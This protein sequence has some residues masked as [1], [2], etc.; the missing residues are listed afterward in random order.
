MSDK[1][2]S[3][4]TSSKPWMRFLY[5]VLFSLALYVAIFVTWF[6][7][8]A[9]FLFSLFT[10]SDNLPLRRFC[11]SFS[12]FIYQVIRYLT[13]N[14]E[15]KP[16]PFSDWPEQSMVF[17][18]EEAFDEFPDLQSDLDQEVGPASVDDYANVDTALDSDSTAMQAVDSPAESDAVTAANDEPVVQ[19]EDRPD[20]AGETPPEQVNNNDEDP[21]DQLAPDEKRER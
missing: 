11:D 2:N 12:T 4:L 6:L 15:E 8:A 5:M 13:Y 14:T 1:L 10:G 3:N 16:F 19:A 20:Q 21:E 9:Q 17:D 18:V 7:V